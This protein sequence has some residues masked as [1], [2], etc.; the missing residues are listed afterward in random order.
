[1]REHPIPQDIT[2]YKFHIIGSMTLKQFLEIAIGV[3]VGNIALF[4]V[5]ILRLRRQIQTFGGVVFTAVVGTK[6][7]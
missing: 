3:I 6:L 1:M 5:V 2:G 4:P 7:R